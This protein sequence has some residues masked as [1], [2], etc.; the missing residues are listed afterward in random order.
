MKVITHWNIFVLVSAG[1]K[2][3]FF[4][5]TGTGLCFGFWRRI[6]P[7]THQCLTVAKQCFLWVRDFSVSHA[8]ALG[9]CMRS[10]EGHAWDSCPELAK[11]MFHMLCIN[12]GEPL[13]DAGGQAE[14][15]SVGGER[16]SFESLGIKSSW[17]LFHALFSFYNNNNNNNNMM[18]FL[19][20]LFILLLKLFTLLDCSYLNTWVSPFFQVSSPLHLGGQAVN[21]WLWGS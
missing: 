12:W 13:A 16:L 6:T 3:I 2:S 18:L 1:I 7:I 20:I 17:F 14:H 9:S 4:S 15:P 21:Q 10:W 8:L 5:V 19:L 11:G